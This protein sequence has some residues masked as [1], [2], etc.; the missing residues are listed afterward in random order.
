MVHSS[1]TQ[2]LNIKYP[3]RISEML[4]GKDVEFGPCI[5]PFPKKQNDPLHQKYIRGFWHK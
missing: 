3:T 5:F 1:N 4:Y 2:L